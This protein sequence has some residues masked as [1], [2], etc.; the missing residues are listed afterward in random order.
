MSPQREIENSAEQCMSRME[1]ESL[2][3]KSEPGQAMGIDAF[4]PTIGDKLL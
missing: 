2:K 3:N 1:L 4:S